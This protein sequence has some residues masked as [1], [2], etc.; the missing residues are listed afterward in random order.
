[1]TSEAARENEA[2]SEEGN[3]EESRNQ[4]FKNA[5]GRQNSREHEEIREG[6]IPKD[7]NKDTKPIQKSS[8]LLDVKNS[9][10]V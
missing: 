7:E 10:Q 9:A 3:D 8:N 4:D 6:S 5:A 2:F 1:M